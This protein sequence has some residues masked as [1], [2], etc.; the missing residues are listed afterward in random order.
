MVDPLHQFAI[1]PLVDWHLG[2]WDISLTNSS[3]MMIVITASVCLLLHLS[4]RQKKLIPSRGQAACELFSKFVSAQVSEQL[5]KDGQVAFPCLFSLFAFVLTANV[6]GLFPYGFTVTSHIIVTFSLALL[7]F[8][9]MTVWG[10]IRHRWQFF[11]I[12]FPRGLPVFM[13]PLLVPVELISYCAR[14]VSLAVR[15]FANMV[16]GHVMI[17]IVAGAAV[18]CASYFLGVFSA[19]S[20][21][22]DAG[23]M[24]FELFV[25]LLQAYVFTI[26]SCI[27]LNSVLNLE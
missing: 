20:V 27:Y 18:F 21:L 17:K 10:I 4:T 1:H 13:A 16:A 7:V 6:F 15:L 9:G 23:L 2:R 8:V 3:L 24:V 12:F 26:L 19:A 25:S 5:G 14:P 11:R 22:I